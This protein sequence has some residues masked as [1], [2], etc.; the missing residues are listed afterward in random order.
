M[1]ANKSGG[2]RELADLAATAESPDGM[3]G[4]TVGAFGDLRELYLDPRHHRSRDA[5]MLTENIMA[6]VRAA[7]NAAARLA[8][9]V[10]AAQLPPGTEPGEADLL[11]GP[12]L[13]ELNR[14]ETR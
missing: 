4:A 13:H 12:A 1:T 6:T 8:F 2:Q 11:F 5:A 9:D 14:L 3:V 10:I 7:E